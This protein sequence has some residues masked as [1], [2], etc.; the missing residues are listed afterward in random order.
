MRVSVWRTYLY[1]LAHLYEGAGGMEGS[2]ATGI[3]VGT[4]I[5]VHHLYKVHTLRL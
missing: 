3:Q 2:G 1:F 5:V 4:V